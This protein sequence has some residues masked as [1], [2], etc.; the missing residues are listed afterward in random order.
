MFVHIIDFLTCYSAII[1]QPKNQIVAQAK[2]SFVPRTHAAKL[3]GFVYGMFNIGT[4]LQE[5]MLE[6]LPVER[7][8]EK[9][10]PGKL[11]VV[12][13]SLLGW[14]SV[15]ASDV[16]N[17]EELIDALRCSCAVFPLVMPHRFRG[18]RCFDGFFSEGTSSP[19][20]SEEESGVSLG[21]NSARVCV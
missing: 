12:M 8:A 20:L 9:L 11:I 4:Y 13:A 14:N 15:R 21:R 1:P 2:T 17:G 5:S 16:E 10:H 6:C 19:V 3:F 18:K 7:V